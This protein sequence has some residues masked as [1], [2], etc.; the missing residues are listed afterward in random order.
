LIIFI[1]ADNY[2]VLP[3]LLPSD[4]VGAKNRIEVYSLGRK[5]FKLIGRECF[6]ICPS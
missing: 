2:W 6:R 1:I 4:R 3:P 5:K